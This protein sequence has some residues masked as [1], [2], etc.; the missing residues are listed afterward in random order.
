MML[1]ILILFVAI[2]GI[3]KSESLPESQKYF[4]KMKYYGKL[5][6]PLFLSKLNTYFV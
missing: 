6:N 3:C 1:T 2:P 5:L 4:Q